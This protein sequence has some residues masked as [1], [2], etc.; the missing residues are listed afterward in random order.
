LGAGVGA[1]FSPQAA[2]PAVIMIANSSDRLLVILIF[3]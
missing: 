2:S 1:G 3:L